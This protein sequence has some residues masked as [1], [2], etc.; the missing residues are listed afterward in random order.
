MQAKCLPWSPDHFKP[1][2]HSVSIYGIYCAPRVCQ[3]LGIY[4]Q[5]TKPS[6]CPLAGHS[7]TGETDINGPNMLIWDAF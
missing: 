1:F 6:A 3:V 4:D 5:Q 2:I 7:L